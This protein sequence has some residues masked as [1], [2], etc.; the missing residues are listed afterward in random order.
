V[1]DADHE[2]D[3]DPGDRE[4]EVRPEHDPHGRGFADGRGIPPVQDAVPGGTTRL[5]FGV[6]VCVALGLVNVAAGLEYPPLCVNAALLLGVAGYAWR[7]IRRA[8]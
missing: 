5:V 2:E 7:E 4:Q 6:V 1:V 3:D 8:A